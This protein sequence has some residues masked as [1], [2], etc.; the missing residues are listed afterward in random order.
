VKPSSIAL[1]VL[2]V[3]LPILILA[4]AARRIAESEQSLVQRRFRQLVEDRL[5]DVNKSIARHFENVERQLEPLT[6]I[7]AIEVETMR[8]LTRTEPRV[9]QL[10][11]ISEK[12]SLLYPDPAQPL[13][14]SEQ[15]FLLS[16]AKMFTGQDLRDAV[17]QKQNR[18]DRN[19]GVD[20]QIVSQFTQQETRYN[21][22][23]VDT[24]HGWFVWYWDRGLNLIYWQRRPSGQI[25]GV[26]LE[27]GRWIADLI[28][29]LPDTPAIEAPSR[30]LL[31]DPSPTAF[32]TRTRLV[33]ASS[34]TVYQWGSLE[35]PESDKPICEVPVAAP[36]QSWRLQGFVSEESAG[37]S[38]WAASAGLMGGLAAVAIALSLMAWVLF[39]DY[40]AG[41]REAAQQ[42]SFV[43]QVSHELKTP[44][45]NIRLYAELLERDLAALPEPDRSQGAGRLSVILSESQRLSRLIGN[46][47]TLAKQKRRTLQPH[48]RAIVPDELIVQTVDRFRPSLEH[49]AIQVKLELNANEPMRIDPD[50]LEQILNNLINNVEKY[51]ADGGLMKLC[52]EQDGQRLS[53]VVE[54]A[55]RG[56]PRTKWNEV[57][58][59]FARLSISIHESAGTGIGLSI[60]RELAK[61]H[62]GNV[63]LES[64]PRGCRFRITLASRMPT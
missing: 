20:K 46:V 35:V 10:F 33:N 53:I 6:R 43:N 45:T 15:S 11:A 18:V 63:E 49:L 41:M 51:A 31:S 48:L 21:D 29:E 1:F 14:G 25:V 37:V 32:S 8:Q 28:S 12:G 50:F 40:S 56:I 3:L 44:L 47:L 13:N 38:G 58:R 57:F 60:A 30:S 2:I 62:G 36:L 54:D 23:A 17:L 55:G 5:Q 52:S 42:V 24:S 22:N 26:A 61:I 27:R 19:L 34:E 9:L 16:T 64:S 7:D 59:P 39:R 4:W